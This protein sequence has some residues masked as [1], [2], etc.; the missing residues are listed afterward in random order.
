MIDK[1]GMVDSWPKL[2]GSLAGLAAPLVV[3]YFVF[4]AVSDE[5]GMVTAVVLLVCL[6]WFAGLQIMVRDFNGATAEIRERLDALED[7]AK[8]H[9]ATRVIVPVATIAPGDPRS[10]RTPT[11]ARRMIKITVITRMTAG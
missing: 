1:P 11:A 3:A 7:V 2:L 8:N 9:S 4:D 6:A 5:A 10:A